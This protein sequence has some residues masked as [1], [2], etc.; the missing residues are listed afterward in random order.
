MVL[1]ALVGCAPDA[2]SD[3]EA[4]GTTAVASSAPGSGAPPGS[5]S[6]ARIGLP[7]VLAGRWCTRV[8]ED[9]CFDAAEVLAEHPGAFVDESGPDDDVPGATVY[10]I[11]LQDEGGRTCSMA[12]TMILEF[13]PPGVA[14]DCDV[15]EVQRNGW[16][17]CEPDTRSAHDVEEGR[18]VHL[19]NHQQD[20]V[21]HDAYPMYLVDG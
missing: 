11:C 16:P 6:T 3:G 4:A 7:P 9:E 1:A 8:G 19:F 13:F 21:Y 17:S 18:L 2:A 14:W 15:V 5:D 12:E 20:T 10:A